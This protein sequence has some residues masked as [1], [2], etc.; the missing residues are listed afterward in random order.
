MMPWEIISEMVKKYY[1]AVEF[2]N[3][4]QKP[5]QVKLA[6]LE[7]QQTLSTFREIEYYYFGVDFSKPN[8]LIDLVIPLFKRERQ[9]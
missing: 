2:Y 7:I 9:R 6:K 5:D 8:D 3:E 4:T 1:R